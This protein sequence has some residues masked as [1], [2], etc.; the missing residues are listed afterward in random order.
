MSAP[1]F[2]RLYLHPDA[3]WD[4][5]VYSLETVGLDLR[6]LDLMTLSA[7]ET[8]LGRSGHL[9]IRSVDLPAALFVAGVAT[10]VSTLWPVADPPACLFFETLYGELAKQAGKLDAFAQRAVRAAWPD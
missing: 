5:I 4:G 2:Q 8:A 9:P 7:C 6:H 1:E 3:G 10:I